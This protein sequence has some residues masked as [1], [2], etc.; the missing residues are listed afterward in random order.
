MIATQ[1]HNRIAAH[2]DSPAAAKREL[3]ETE[4]E[5]GRFLKTVDALIDAQLAED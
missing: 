4:H 5:R 3:P 2:L 1:P